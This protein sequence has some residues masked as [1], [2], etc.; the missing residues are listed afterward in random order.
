MHA[1]QY[2]RSDVIGLIHEAITFHNR[3]RSL[4]NT[5]KRIA[6]KIDPWGRG[7]HESIFFQRP[8]NGAVFVLSSLCFMNCFPAHYYE[9]QPSR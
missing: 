9:I 8:E 5:L 3:N 1:Y 4:E 7:I 6:P 2:T